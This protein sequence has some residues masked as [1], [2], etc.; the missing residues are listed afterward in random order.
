M[1]SLVNVLLGVLLVSG[2]AA[3]AAPSATAAVCPGAGQAPVVVGRAPGAI[4]GFTVDARG[5]A[6][7]TAIGNSTLFRIDAPGAPA[8]PIATLPSGGG[9]LAWAPDGTLLVG[10]GDDPRVFVGDALRHAGIVRV[11]IDTLAVTPFV[12]GLSAANGMAVA[13]DGTVYAT[14]DFGNLVARILPNGVVQP[15]WVRFPSANGAVLS[16]DGAWLYVSRTFANQGVSRIST[17]NGSV[18]SLAD[19]GGTDLLKFADGLTLDSL[20]RPVVPANFA[21]EV[22]RIDGFNQ[23]CTLG[24]GMPQSSVVSYGRGT[25]GFAQ[26]RLFRAGFDGN[27]FEVPGGFDPN[28]TTATP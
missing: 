13:R 22:I 6:Y 25:T 2:F 19:F 27:V 4:E 12:T 26:G 11:D 3:I 18:Q 17:I 20:G 9:A 14:N 15:D 5:R 28:A 16:A 1:R 10:T 21:G 23:F 24:S 7:V 8:V